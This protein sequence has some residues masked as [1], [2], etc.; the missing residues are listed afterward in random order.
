MVT[1]CADLC[2]VENEGCS[3]RVKDVDS[4]ECFLTVNDVLLRSESDACL[5]V[6]VTPAFV[7]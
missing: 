6:C 7:L 3:L 1:L 4:T 2:A 5:C